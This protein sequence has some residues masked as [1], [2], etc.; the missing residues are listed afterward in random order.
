MLRSWAQT[1]GPY[2]N[3]K[4]VGDPPPV[5]APTAAALKAGAGP[6][7]IVLAA[8]THPGEEALIAQAFRAAVADGLAGG[9]TRRP[10]PP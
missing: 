5:D 6:R 4:L 8:S 10:P 9:P 7:K 3:L 2:L 1:V